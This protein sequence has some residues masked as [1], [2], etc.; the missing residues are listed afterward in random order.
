MVAGALLFGC[1]THNA[2][3]DVATLL[4]YGYE[5]AAATGIEAQLGAIIPYLVDDVACCACQVYVCLAIDFAG[6]D[7]LA[8]GNQ[9][10]AGHFAVGIACQEFIDDGIGYLV[11]N[12]VGMPFGYGFRCE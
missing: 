1:L 2:A 11:G 5:Y 3:V 6:D 10:L 12:L 9:C 8:G 4:V 7:D